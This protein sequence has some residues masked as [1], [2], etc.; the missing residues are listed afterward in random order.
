[1]FEKSRNHAVF[2]VQRRPSDFH[3]IKITY[4]C[5]NLNS[6]GQEMLVW[7]ITRSGLNFKNDTFILRPSKVSILVVV[8]EFWLPA[9][10]RNP[11]PAI[12]WW[13]GEV[14]V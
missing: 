2:F 6:R 9:N 13:G 7:F 4:N 14:E 10:P 1:M 5:H 8:V 3:T 11:Y 12:L